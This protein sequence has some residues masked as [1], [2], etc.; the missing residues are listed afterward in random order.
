MTASFLRNEQFDLVGR[1]RQGFEELLRK[2]DGAR[3][4]LIP[5]G[6]CVVGTPNDE[7]REIEA[8]VPWY[9]ATI[10]ECPEARP[11]LSGYLIDRYEVTSAMFAN[12]LNA[13]SVRAVSRDGVPWAIDD[14]GQLLCVDAV[15]FVARRG[16][17]GSDHAVGVRYRDGN[18]VATEGAEHCPITLVTWFGALAYARFVGGRLPTEMEWEKAARGPDGRR[19]PWGD[20]YEP[21]RTNT[22]DRWLGREIPDQRSWEE[23]FHQNGHG[24]A[25]LASRPLPIGSIRGGES[26]FGCEDMIGNVA[27]W[28]SDIWSE[29]PWGK[30]EGKKGSATNTFRSMRGAGRYGYR[31]IARCAC[32]RRRD[33]QSVSENLG[34]RCAFTLE[35]SS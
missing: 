14:T 18:W 28:C 17:S 7:A 22:A 15:E 1:N 2:R 29:G 26:F 9:P 24:P 4:I 34:F 6:S 32:R 27:E 25:W 11:V 20:E 23:D 30:I 35:H 33:P 3:V 8:R 21:D 19:F 5:A 13:V 10:A 16:I 12:F 31:A